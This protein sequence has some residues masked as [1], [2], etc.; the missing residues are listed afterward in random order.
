MAVI[1][2]EL[3]LRPDSG[4]ALYQAVERAKA[5]AAAKTLLHP[6]LLHV[7]DIYV[8][9]TGEQWRVFSLPAITEFGVAE[10]V[11]VNV[12]A[13]DPLLVHIPQRREGWD[14]IAATVG[15]AVMGVF[16]HYIALNNL[17]I[18]GI[19]ESEM[20]QFGDYAAVSIGERWRVYVRRAEVLLLQ[21]DDRI[22][23][24]N[25]EFL[26]DAP[27]SDDGFEISAWLHEVGV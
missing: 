5:I 3:W 15:N 17:T 25:R 18:W 23:M 10:V 7:V 2:H 24:G 12:H 20:V 8:I 1:R 22:R 26:V 21:R 14:N 11:A 13:T 4:E 9:A 19:V 16:G 27:V 6:E